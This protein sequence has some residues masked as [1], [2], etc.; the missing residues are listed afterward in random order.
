MLCGK[1]NFKHLEIYHLAH[2]FVLHSYFL[3]ESFPDSESN[4]FVSQLKRAATSVPLNIAEGSGCGSFRA[5]FNF[6]SFSYRSCL[7]ID[8]ILALCRDLKYFSDK[9]YFLSYEKLNCLTRKL[10]RYMEYIENQA[11]K[12]SGYRKNN[13]AASEYIK[14]SSGVQ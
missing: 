3:C 13:P 12:R 8:A 11:D 4:N 5:F 7:E 14:K 6:L 10:Y 2:D 1:F 9:Q